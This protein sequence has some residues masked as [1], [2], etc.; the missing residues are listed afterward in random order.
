MRVWWS[1]LE[2]GPLVSHRFDDAGDVSGKVG[3]WV[4]SGCIEER[5]A[6]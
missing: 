2:G 4:A 5:R 6:D 3:W 1:P